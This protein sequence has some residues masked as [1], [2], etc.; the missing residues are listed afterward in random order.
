MKGSLVGKIG[1]LDL[2]KTLKVACYLAAAAFISSVGQAV[3]GADFSTLSF[4]GVNGQVVAAGVVNA[5]LYFG[6]RL[7]SN[8][9]K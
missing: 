3:S 2:A 8:T 5:I 1:T 4:L 9:D 7:L 6:N